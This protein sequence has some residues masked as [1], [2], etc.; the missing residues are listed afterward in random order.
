MMKKLQVVVL[1]LVF[2]FILPGQGQA[3]DLRFSEVLPQALVHSYDLKMGGMEKEISKER[4]TEAGA[5]YFPTLDLRFTNEYMADFG[6]G[7]G[8]TVS[9]GETISPGNE[10]T[11][12]HS[13]ALSAQYI[14]YDFGVRGLKYRNAELG[15]I[16]TEHSTAQRLIDLKGEVLS[17]FGTGLQLQKKIETWDALLSL[18]KEVYGFTQ[19]LVTS[20][21]KGKPEQGI[22]AIG[23]AEALQNCEALRLD[24]AGVLEKLTYYTGENY[25]GAEVWFTDLHAPAGAQASADVSRLPGIRSYD[26]AIEQKNAEKDIALRHWLPTLSLYSSYRM[27][28]DDKTNFM[29]SLES[30][31]EK[32]ASIGLVVNMNLFNGFSDEAKARRL[33]IELQKLQIEKEKKVAEDE[34]KVRTLMQ[35]SIISEQGLGNASIYRDA[36]DD[37]TTMAERLSLQQIIDRISLLQQKGAQMEKHLTLALADVERCVNALQLQIMA[38]GALE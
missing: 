24:M 33:Q 35:K 21:G 26:V 10:S 7:A 34:Q 6:K 12:Q 29:D 20:G 15:I 30:L 18:R 11:F 2:V 4:L 36:L 32:N 37:Q 23:V 13:V 31:E 5:M 28:G 8:N 16:L 19:R 25:Q 22:A 1:F 14:L 27:Y 9:V 38:E 3:K 17:L